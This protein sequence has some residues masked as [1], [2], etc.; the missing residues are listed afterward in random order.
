MP[1]AALA[2]SLAMEMGGKRETETETAQEKN[3]LS[4]RG[5][6]GEATLEEPRFY[7]LKQHPK[8]NNKQKKNQ[9]TKTMI[10]EQQHDKQI[11][12][13]V[14]ITISD[15]NFNFRIFLERNARGRPGGRSLNIL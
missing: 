12:L 6:E 1:S 8:T 5:R 10:H 3:N 9:Q 13:Q 11:T 14:T 2:I 7:L 15:S 4:C